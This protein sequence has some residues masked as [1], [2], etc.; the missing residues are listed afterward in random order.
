VDREGH[1]KRIDGNN[2]VYSLFGGR[3]L[4]FAA[5]RAVGPPEYLILM[6]ISQYKEVIKMINFSEYYVLEFS[7][8]Q[9][10]WHIDTLERTL[11]RN[12]GWFLKGPKGN[13]YKILAISKNEDELRE[14]KKMLLEQ[15][16]SIK[17]T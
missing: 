10:A 17:T 15:K 4:R 2:S 1:H 13:D 7:L 3:S 5:L 12:M 11:K 14:I 6:R 8:T 9:N 16:K